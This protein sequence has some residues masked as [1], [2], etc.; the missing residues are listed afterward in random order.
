MAVAIYIAGT[1]GSVG[2]AKSLHLLGAVEV[3]E[4]LFWCWLMLPVL[5]PADLRRQGINC[6][7]LT[8]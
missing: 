1:N 2:G 6:R 8:E 3:D 7:V 4:E 5:R